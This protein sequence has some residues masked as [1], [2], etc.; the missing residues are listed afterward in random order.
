MANPTTLITNAT[1]SSSVLFSTGAKTASFTGSPIPGVDTF[2]AA[3]FQLNVTAVTGTSP[4]MNVYIQ[5]LLPD[6]ATWTDLV[7]FAQVTGAIDKVFE[8]VGQ[9]NSTYTATDAT[10]TAG[11]SQT[12]ILGSTH[13]VKVVIGGTNPSFTFTLDG[14]Y[15]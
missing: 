12:A 5:K 11:T 10:L 3:T 6:Q 4:T 15:V 14:Q 13:R 8:V 9:G 7:S 2:S 1:S